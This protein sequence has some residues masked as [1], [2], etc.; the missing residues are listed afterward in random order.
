MADGGS[1]QTK[2]QL[3]DRVGGDDRRP[4]IDA[5]EETTG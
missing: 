3:P 1:V 2:A 4:R 5:V